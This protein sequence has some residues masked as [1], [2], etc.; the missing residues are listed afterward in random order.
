MRSLRRILL[1]AALLLPAIASFAARASGQGRPVFNSRATSEF[2]GMFTGYEAV[3][4]K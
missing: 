2:Y 1:A 4:I 3:A